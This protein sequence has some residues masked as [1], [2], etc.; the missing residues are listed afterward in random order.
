MF[1]KWLRDST[2]LKPDKAVKE[3]EQQIEKLEKKISAVKNENCCSLFD[4]IVN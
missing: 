1:L 3:K 4:I 2:V